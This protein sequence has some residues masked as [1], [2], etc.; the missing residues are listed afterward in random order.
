MLPFNF[1]SLERKQYVELIFYN[2]HCVYSCYKYRIQ[3]LPNINI[4]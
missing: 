4:K 1:L 2:R 3:N